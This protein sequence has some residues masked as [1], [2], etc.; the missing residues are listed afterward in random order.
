MLD[1]IPGSSDWLVMFCNPQ[2]ADQCIRTECILQTIFFELGTV[3]RQIETE[4]AQA[5]VEV[6]MI[7]DLSSVKNVSLSWFK[8]QGA[9][10][11]EICVRYVRS[12][13]SRNTSINKHKINESSV[14]MEDIY[15]FFGFSV[16]ST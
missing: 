3:F 12:M 8:L 14:S 2:T 9:L 16:F 15:N 13:V 7:S 6:H 4:N 1:Y 10:V 11:I 5:D